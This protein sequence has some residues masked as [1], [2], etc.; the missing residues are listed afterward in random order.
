MFAVTFALVEASVV[1]YL[2]ELFYPEGF[3]FPLTPLPQTVLNIEIAREAATIL[4]LGSAGIMAGRTP[5]QRFSYFIYCFGLWDIF[6]Y[7]WLKVFIGWPESF[8]TPD[9]L[10][11]LPVVWWSPVLAPMIVAFSLCASAIVIVRQLE[12]GWRPVLKPFDIVWVTIGAV[13]ILYTFM[14]DSPLIEQGQMPPPFRWLWFFAGEGIGI[15][16]FVR[17]MLRKISEPGIIK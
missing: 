16:A 7:V 1:I 13:I 8:L 17:M 10:F 3:N 12:K 9:V 5:W 2:R 4:M 6:Y 15:I 14:A 11:L